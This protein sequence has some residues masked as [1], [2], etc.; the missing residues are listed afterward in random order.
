MNFD[1]YEEK[2]MQTAMEY[3]DQALNYGGLG[4]A[5]EAGEVAGKLKRVIRDDN[6]SLTPEMK[7]TLKKELGDVLWYLNF[8]AVQLGIPLKEVAQA[9]IDKLKDRQTREVIKGEGDER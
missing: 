7:E 2:A 6:N 4:L 5:S 9:N 1:E 3:G 8:L